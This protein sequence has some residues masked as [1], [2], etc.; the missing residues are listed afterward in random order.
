MIEK[1]D[2]EK[3]KKLK[4]NNILELSLI[5][6]HSYEDNYIYTEIKPYEQVF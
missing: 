1:D 6:P 2:L 5:I 3:F 4:I